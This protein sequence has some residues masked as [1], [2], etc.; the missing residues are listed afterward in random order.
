[1]LQSEYESLSV[2]TQLQ[3][4]SYIWR[5]EIGPLE[6]RSNFAGQSNFRLLQNPEFCRHIHKDPLPF[7]TLSQ[8]ETI[9]ILLILGLSE[10]ES[11]DS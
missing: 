10:T 6:N 4:W 5:S 2:R 1:M 3:D 7:T 8:L 11:L 9:Q